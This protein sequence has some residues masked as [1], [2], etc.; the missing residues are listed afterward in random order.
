MAEREF[1]ADMNIIALGGYNL[2]LGVKWMETVSPITFDFSAG[3]ITINWQ[4]EKLILQQDDRLP[5]IT[6]EAEAKP[7][8]KY[9]SEEVYFLVKITATEGHEVKEQKA[10]KEIQALLNE[11]G[12]IFSNPTG[13]PPQR[14]QDH[15]I[16][17]KPGSQPVNSRP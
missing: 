2:I 17:I 9:N 7:R 3:N 6:V 11:Y 8:A 4:H 10:S 14:A 1:M 13:L 5:T 16:P 12:E 15:S